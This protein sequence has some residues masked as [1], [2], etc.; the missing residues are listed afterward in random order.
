M[1]SIFRFIFTSTSGTIDLRWSIGVYFRQVTFSVSSSLDGTP[2]LPSFWQVESLLFRNESYKNLSRDDLCHNLTLESRKFKHGSPSLAIKNTPARG[3]AEKYTMIQRTKYQCTRKKLYIAITLS[4]Y[5]KIINSPISSDSTPVLSLP[6]IQFQRR[7]WYWFRFRFGTKLTEQTVDTLD[8]YGC[9][10]N[11]RQVGYQYQR[12]DWKVMSRK[13]D[14]GKLQ[15]SPGSSV[16]TISPVGRPRYG[17]G[18][19]LSQVV[20]WAESLRVCFR[21]VLNHRL[22]FS[23]VLL[24]FLEDKCSCS[25]SQLKNTPDS[26]RC[27]QLILFK[28]R[29][30]RNAG[31]RVRI[32]SF[33]TECPSE[34]ACW[35]LRMNMPRVYSHTWV[36]S[37]R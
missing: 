13:G 16:T 33:L 24:L 1:F 28:R 27:R 7:F 11:T 31:T 9:S 3:E 32:S 25:G 26:V 18:Q 37:I 17:S 12:Y 35:R 36:G 29:G 4:I 2:F 10:S 14:R 20:C 22:N 19:S 5:S 30:L 15:D 8:T 21:G 23:S 34:R 6:E